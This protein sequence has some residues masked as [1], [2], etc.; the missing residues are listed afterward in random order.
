MQGRFDLWGAEEMTEWKA[1]VIIAGIY[2]GI[3]AG[4]TM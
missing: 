4:V 3:A 2:L 1:A